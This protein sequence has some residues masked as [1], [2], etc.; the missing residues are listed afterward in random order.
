MNQTFP[1]VGMHCAGC[2]DNLTKAI[3]KVP[4]VINA[5][6]TY[7]TDST[8]IE[9]DQKIID[10][11]A[12]KKAVASVGSYKIIL[13]DHSSHQEH[14]SALSDQKLSQLKTKTI[15]SG[16]FTVLL[17]FGN[18]FQFIPHQLSF[19][20]TSIVMFYSGQEFFVNAW[21]GLKKFLAN[22]DSLIAMGTGAAYLYS[23]AVT[24]FPDLFSTPQPVYFETAASIITLILLG[25]Y[26]E[27]VAKGK[28][29]Q[30]IKKLLNL[31]AKKAIVLVK[32]QEKE[33]DISM[34]KVGDH[35][36]VK[37]GAKVPVDAIVIKGQSYLDESLVTGESK[38]V[39]K[40]KDDKVI[41]STINKQ[42]LLIIE[43]SS[44]GQDTLLSQIVKLVNEAQASQ[45]PI[46]K[47][48][49]KISSIFVPSVI[50]I[51]ILAFLVWYFVLGLAFSPSLV[52]AITILIVSCPCA[53]GLATPISIMVSTGKGA[54]NGVLIKN[55]EKLQLAGQIETIVFDKT[56]T[57]TQ[58]NFAVTDIIPADISPKWS[59]NDILKLSASLELGSEH[60]IGEAIVSKAKLLKLTLDK[61]IDFQNIEGLGVSGK[62]GNSN[63]LLGNLKLMEQEKV[64]R[65]STLD[66]SIQ[67]LAEQGKTIAYL[68]INQ[69]TVGALAL[70]DEPKPSAEA[71]V[72][73]LQQKNLAVW[74]ITGDNQP[75]GEAIAHRLGIKNIMANVLPK[76]KVAKVKELQQSSKVVAMVGDGVNDAPALAQA[77]IGITMATGTDVAIEAGDV[78]LLRGDLNLIE[79]AINLSQKTLTNIK[80]N[81]FWAFGYNA[82][83]IPIAV[84]VLKPVGVTISPIFASGAMA[85]SSL[86]VVLNALRLKRIKL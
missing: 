29:S 26:L 72:S 25:R 32:G 51:A 60:P 11:T 31:Q 50:L 18:W 66:D 6:V 38:P 49:D 20:L 84:G 70:E 67:K 2:A 41:G 27:S 3:K 1:I 69:K 9:Y 58:G 75:T 57:L 80:Q 4:G 83:L 37:P 23:T 82:L 78:T 62:V 44:V 14:A 40:N 76:D 86:S 54:E 12:I 17:L 7:S 56:G 52:I 71:V 61:P 43:A 55:A 24:F 65:C 15:V 39:K 81:L 35:L 77:E 16:L 21:L 53:L 47:L 68:S 19:I 85:F 33:I 46:Q 64:T 45:A 22:M 34:V 8:T 63:I 74:M 13:P 48:A 30:A 28:A 59:S 79:K 73:A 10:W 42:G 5:S 36:V